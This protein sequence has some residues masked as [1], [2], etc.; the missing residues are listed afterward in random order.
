MP[1]EEI[2]FFKIKIGTSE[3]LLKSELRENYYKC[4]SIV[5]KTKKKKQLNK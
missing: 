2:I 4:R 1:Y 3:N 5:L